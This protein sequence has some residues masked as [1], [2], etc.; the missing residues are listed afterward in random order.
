MEIFLVDLP[1]KCGI[2]VVIRIRM[3]FLLDYTII[4]RRFNHPKK[5]IYSFKFFLFFL[6]V[7]LII[8]ILF[9]IF[10]FKFNSLFQKD[11]KFQILFFNDLHYNPFYN[12]NGDPKHWCEGKNLSDSLSYQYGIYGCDS[13]DKLYSSLIETFKYL[14]ITP[15]LIIFCGDSLRFENATMKEINQWLFKFMTDISKLFPNIP[16]MMTLGNTEYSPSYGSYINDSN[17]FQSLSQSFSF[18]LNDNQLLTFKKGGYYFQD[19][20]SHH[21]RIINL[22]SILYN[23]KHYISLNLNLSLNNISDPW[24]QFEWLENSI[25]DAKIKKLEPLIVTHI[26]PNKIWYP[27]GLI[28]WESKYSIS[29]FKILEKYDIQP[30]LVGHSHLDLIMP[31]YNYKNNYNN[32]S[33]NNYSSEFVAISSPS[34]SPEHGNNPG[35]R[36]YTIENGKLSD[37]IQWTADL[38]LGFIDDIQWKENYVFSKYYGTN[39]FRHFPKILKENNNLMK[40]YVHTIYGN[41]SPW[42]SFAYC[43]TLSTNQTLFDKCMKERRFTPLLDF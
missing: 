43:I 22:N 29:F 18:F 38:S 30:I 2:L 35:F 20:P 9:G 15:S 13:S 14:K 4:E 36:I 6:I 10:T 37:Y 42:S 19:F 7:L 16:F 21:L 40:K 24:D 3:K 26:P 25:K 28:G 32:N 5:T 1:L 17:T 12:P 31:I 11:K 8:M 33:N 41:S 34:V 39:D 23:H 27:N